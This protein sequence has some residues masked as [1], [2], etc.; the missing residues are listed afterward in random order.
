MSHASIE[1]AIGSRW[2]GVHRDVLRF[3]SVWTISISD[4]GLVYAR[5]RIDVLTGR[6]LC[7]LLRRLSVVWD[8]EFP[9]LIAIDLVGIQVRPLQRDNFHRQLQRFADQVGARLIDGTPHNGNPDFVLFVRIE[10]AFEGQAVR[11]AG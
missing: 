6:D 7:S 4:A 2:S 8:R 10:P 9:R 1:W 3:L 11:S 5:P